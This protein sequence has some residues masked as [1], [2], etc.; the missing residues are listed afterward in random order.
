MLDFADLPY[1]FVSPRPNALVI[2]LC[3]W[4]NRTFALPG[5]NHR[6]AGIELW[7]ADR[8]STA[9]ATPAARFVL[10]PNH[11]THSDPQLLTEVCRRLR[12][13][14]AFMAAYDVFARSKLNRWVMRRTGA[15]SV[16]REGSDRAAM[17]CAGEI[18]A[19]GRQALVVFPE[20]NVYL[21][22][23]RVTP[24]NEG[25][26]YIALRS[27]KALGAEVPV[28]AVPV[29][30]KY[31]HTDDVRDPVRTAF[32]SLADLTGTPMAAGAPFVDEIKRVGTAALARRL[33]QRGYVP[34]AD[35]D[36]PADLQ[37]DHAAR[38]LIEGL[39]RKIGLSPRPADTLATRVRK[40]RA[41][42]HAVR[43]D[44]GREIDHRPAAS[45]ADEAILAL[46]ILGYAGGY[47]SERPS[48][49]RIAE[50]V[51]RLRE[52]LTS[53][54]H[55]PDGTRR[56][57]VEIGTPIDL[58]SRLDAF[59]AEAREAVRELTGDCEAAVQA[60]VDRLNQDNALPGAEFF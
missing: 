15:F 9:R 4:A 26:A 17:K 34:A 42:I 54:L 14:P 3:R 30:L 49:D 28:F 39:E 48:L 60:G 40:A 1:E 38:Q 56:A 44:P 55:P 32:S 21:C 46:R 31:S 36:A 13:K 29:A 19:S 41:A 43:T 8:F 22:N 20:G 6:I 58:R 33:T 16:D 18:L 59:A 2:A 11:P 45:W 53:R 27:Q 35:A 7:G 51:A 5:K 24:F 10:L 25:A 50:T 52:D 23:D 47:A 37:I 12:V 57:L